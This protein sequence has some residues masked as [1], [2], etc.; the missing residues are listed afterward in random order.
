[1]KAQPLDSSLTFLPPARSGPR[2]SAY[3]ALQ[4]EI[5]RL[6]KEAEAAR[7]NEAAQAVAWIK[8]AIQAH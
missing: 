4:L 3:Q 7:K 1:M 6:K 5:A 2:R 8:K